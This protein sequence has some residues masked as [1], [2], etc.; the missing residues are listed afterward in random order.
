MKISSN[1]SLSIAIVSYLS[2]AAELRKT[3]ASLLGALQVLRVDA[4]DAV[5]T[6]SII[7]NSESS[8]LKL[9]EFSQLSAKLSA[10]ACELRLIQGHGNVGYGAAHNIA[11]ANT[12]SDYH[13]LM[14]PDVELDPQSLALGI[15][16]LFQNSEVA[17]VSPSASWEGGARQYL[18]KRYPAVFDLFLRGFMPAFVRTVFN[19]RLAE[20]E[21]HDLVDAAPAD[22]IP[23]VSGCFMLCRSEALQK[24]G[25]FNEDYFLYFEDFDLSMRLNELYSLAYLPAMKIVHAGGHSA[26]K[27]LNHIKMFIQSGRRFFSTYGWRWF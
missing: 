15:D 22:N 12:G 23:I 3:L 13:L 19:G 17:V 14:N 1:I 10:L 27:G 8:S 7:D 11:I 24:V 26:S 20:Y 4:P 5:F 21:M 16:Y 18:C 9:D 6:I 2:P 25:G